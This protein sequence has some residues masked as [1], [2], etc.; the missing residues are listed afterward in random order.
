MAFSLDN[1]NFD[2]MG[3]R[4]VAII[5][6]L[7]LV[8]VSIVSFFVRGF[9]F[10]IDFTGGVLVEVRYAQSVEL[11]SVRQSLEQGG[12]PKAV[13]QFFGTSQDVLIRVPPGEGRDNAQVSEGMLKALRGQVGEEGVELRRVEFVGP[14]VGEELANDGFLAVLVALIGIFIYVMLRFEW[15]FSVGAIVATLHDIVITAGMFS[16]VGLEVDLTVLAAMLAVIGYSVNDTVVVFDRIRENFRKLR[17]A[18]PVQTMNISINQTLARTT[19]TSFVTLLAVLALLF[20]GG[21]LIRNFSITLI[22]GIVIG[23]I[24]SI[25]VASAIALWLGVSKADLMPVKKDSAELDA[26]P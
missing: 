22:V 18:E 26:R 21:D 5:L 16:L 3:K 13:V 9:N 6:S 15:R 20:F 24:S 4:R 12:Y 2:F 1:T 11:N 7:T 17:K 10:G 8:A 19:M 23:T 14:Q 25:Y